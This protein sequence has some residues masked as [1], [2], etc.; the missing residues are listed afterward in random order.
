MV[1]TESRRP[2]Y[3]ANEDEK[4][5][6]LASRAAPPTQ[7]RFLNGPAT[8]AESTARA[9]AAGASLAAA[10]AARRGERIPG[11]DVFTEGKRRALK[12]LPIRLLLGIQDRQNLILGLFLQL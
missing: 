4:K 1:D 10:E 5:G 6:Q 7:G 8:P 11:L 2:N 9:L 12:R 3:P